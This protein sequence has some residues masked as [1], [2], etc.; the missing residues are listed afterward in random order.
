MFPTINKPNAD[1]KSMQKT[2]YVLFAV[3]LT[4]AVLKLAAN[5][6]LG[7][8]ELLVTFM[9]LCGI[10]CANYCLI[11]FYIVMMLLST[12]NF[13][14][15]F[16]RAAQIHI[17]TGETPI[18]Q[19]ICFTALFF[20]AV[21]SVIYNI[22]AILVCFGAYRTFKYAIKMHGKDIEKGVVHPTQYLHN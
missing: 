16:G 15:L 14:M 7:I 21:A 6:L 11:V 20:L 8:N 22:I 2:L 12:V 4:L 17:H 9:F 10:C 13:L 3:A 1:V 19:E 5:A 18:G